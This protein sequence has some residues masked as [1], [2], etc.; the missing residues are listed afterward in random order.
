MLQFKA[1]DCSDCLVY[2]GHDAA[3]REKRGTDNYKWEDLPRGGFPSWS[4]NR[5]KK[6]AAGKEPAARV[7]TRSAARREWARA[8]GEATQ[9]EAKPRYLLPQRT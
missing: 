3:E 4:I 7:R 2:R 9:T 5:Y 1:G 8:V 6:R